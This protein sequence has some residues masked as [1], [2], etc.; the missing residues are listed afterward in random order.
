MRNEHDV[1]ARSIAS[2]V[3]TATIIV[4]FGPY[5]SSNYFLLI[6]LAFLL[7]ITCIEI[8]TKNFRNDGTVTHV[9]MIQRGSFLH[10][11]MG[12]KTQ[13]VPNVVK[14]RAYTEHSEVIKGTPKYARKITRPVSWNNSEHVHRN[15]IF[16]KP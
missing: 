12:K 8:Y 10:K 14:R 2:A 6:I 9:A 1:L 15:N 13:S 4:S 3:S 7:L 5:I 16:E 11:S